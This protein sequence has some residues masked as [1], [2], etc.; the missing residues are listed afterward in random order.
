MPPADG[1]A[2]SWIKAAPHRSDVPVGLEKVALTEL[3]PRL[4]RKLPDEELRLAW[5]RLSQ[6]YGSAVRR[7][8]PVEDFVNAGVWVG[9]EMDRRGFAVDDKS[10]LGMAVADFAKEI[11]GRRQEVHGVKGKLPQRLEVMLEGQPEEILLV[12][13][14]VSVVGSAAGFVARRCVAAWA[15][16]E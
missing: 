4:I 8:E 15:R 11:K 5:L 9:D 7:K 12:R 13:D 14:F 3:R 2:A 1:L 6:W 10:P 16:R